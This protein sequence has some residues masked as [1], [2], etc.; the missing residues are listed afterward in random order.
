MIVSLT[1]VPCVKGTSILIILSLPSSVLELVLPHQMASLMR[2]GANAGPCKK[3]EL[4]PRG[5]PKSVAEALTPP[6][7]RSNSP[8]IQA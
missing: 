1:N 3:D 8:Y 6:I 7:A 5:T 2:G 4:C